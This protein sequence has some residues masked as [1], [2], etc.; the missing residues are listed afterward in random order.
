MK[1]ASRKTTQSRD[2]ELCVVN[3]SLT[4]AV[5]ARSIAP[6]LQAAIEQW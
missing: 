6:T 4:H 3:S 1:L 2:G 5:S